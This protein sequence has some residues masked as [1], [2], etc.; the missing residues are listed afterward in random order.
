MIVRTVLE[1]ALFGQVLVDQALYIVVA[2]LALLLQFVAAYDAQLDL[3]SL[4]ELPP[5]DHRAGALL[6]LARTA[7][8]C[9]ALRILLSGCILG[10]GALS[11]AETPR[12]AAHIHTGAQLAGALLLFGI[13]L[14]NL[15][16]TLVSLRGRRQALWRL[17]AENERGSRV[18]ELLHRA[19]N[20]GRG[21]WG[22]HPKGGS[23][24]NGH[25]HGAP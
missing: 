13:A 7:L 12:A 22:G 11:I 24:S 25:G 19:P 1:H 16:A 23:G 18:H 15:L 3:T 14:A 2:A 4:M 10:I 5:A 6:S 8:R 17:T 9:E 20:E 21:G